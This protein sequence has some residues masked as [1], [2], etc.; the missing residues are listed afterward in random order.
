MTIA[1]RR[2]VLLCEGRSRSPR[3]GRFLLLVTCSVLPSYTRWMAPDARRPQAGEPLKVEIVKG[4]EPHRD[5]GWWITTFFPVVIAAAALAVA[6][7]SFTDQHTVDQTTEAAALRTYASAVSFDLAGSQYVIDNNAQAQITSVLVQSAAHASLLRIGA[8]PSCKGVVFSLHATSPVIYFL[9][10]NGVGW[11]LPLDGVAEESVD[12]G[13]LLALL[14]PSAVA[15]SISSF[16]AAGEL[17]P[18]Q[19]NSCS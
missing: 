11:K 6:I 17:P 3:R 13:E 15:I 4:P 14:P 10:A 8:I 16:T 12:P 19:V 9:D 7:W 2:S 5:P 1:S 18:K